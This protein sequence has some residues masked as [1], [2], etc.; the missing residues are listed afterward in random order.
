MSELKERLLLIDG[1]NIFIA[2]NAVTS[3]SDE[4]CNPIGA[5]I[6]TISQ[7]RNFVDKFRPN[8]IIFCIDGANAGER[9]RKL[10]PSYK[11]KRRIKG[12]SSKIVML[13]GDDNKDEFVKHEDQ[14][15]FERQLKQVY[16]FFKL[17]PVSVCVV[18]YCEADDIISYIA[19]KN[20]KEYDVIITSTDKD[21]LQLIND[22]ISVYNWHTKKLY[23]KN[24]FED[25]FK[26]IPKN[27]IFRKIILGDT[28]DEIKNTKSIGIKTF[29]GIFLNELSSNVHLESI[30]D[31]YNYI[32][33]I[34]L[35]D[36][37]KKYHKHIELLKE[38]DTRQSLILKYRIMKLDESC[39]KLNHIELLRQ[40][41][42]EQKNR[43]FSKLSARMK[44]IK[45]SFYKIY[46]QSGIK[47][48]NPD[49][50]LQ[51]FVFVRT[52]KEIIV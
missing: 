32:E 45:D 49:R 46:G 3:I 50:F 41:L 40:E 47:T 28:S 51:P 34:N 10:Y 43:Q 5:Y 8:K 19:L 44:I 21:Y 30:E 2:Q 6:T 25:E 15:G 1:F 35:I 20:Q 37:Q 27:Y 4:N 36:L 52:N 29:E 38:S 39:L 48:F 14:Q 31:F 26:I 24:R 11:G 9:R 22:N 33:L 7:V 18:P 12:R 42:E 13:E 17:L 23:D 16:D